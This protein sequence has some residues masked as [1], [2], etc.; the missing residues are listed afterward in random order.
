MYYARE[1]IG[2]ISELEFEQ[3]ITDHVVKYFEGLRELPERM[4]VFYIHHTVR[5]F[6][7]FLDSN[8]KGKISLEALWKSP[9]LK[10]LLQI[11]EPT[12]ENQVLI[13]NWFSS[14]KAI[15]IYQKYLELDKDRDGMLSPEELLNYGALTPAF[16]QRV[17]ECS[18]VFD[19]KMDYKSF[20]DFAIAMENKDTKEGIAVYINIFLIFLIFFFIVYSISSDYWI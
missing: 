12:D 10:E 13:N 9:L 17:F 18:H 1:E 14:H 2:Y 11:N 4:H 6:L 19:G 8:H 15:L 20:L 5:K 16:I 3:F 7:F